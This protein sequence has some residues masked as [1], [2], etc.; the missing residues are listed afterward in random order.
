MGPS[1]RSRRADCRRSWKPGAAQGL[2]SMT[3]L[4]LVPEFSRSLG[5]SAAV[6]GL[7]HA[8]D[9]ALSFTPGSSATWTH[10]WT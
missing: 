9:H 7:C 5:A 6:G 3:M 4:Y 2:A 1:A 10:T 8:A